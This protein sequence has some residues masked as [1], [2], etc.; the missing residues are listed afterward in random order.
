M[1]VFDHSNTCNQ[2]TYKTRCDCVLGGPRCDEAFAKSCDTMSKRAIC[3]AVRHELLRH[4]RQHRKR[5]HSSLW[6]QQLSSAL[7]RQRPDT[8]P[9]GSGDQW[10]WLANSRAVCATES[11]K[12]VRLYRSEMG[13]LRMWQCLLIADV[14]RKITYIT[15]IVYMEAELNCEL[16]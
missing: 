5:L 14:W 16:Y 2:Y 7:H 11:T 6:H 9:G 3:G 4:R 8:W 13:G 12:L 15:S 10:V 1:R